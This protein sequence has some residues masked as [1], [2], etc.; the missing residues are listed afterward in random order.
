MAYKL[1]L[2]HIPEDELEKCKADIADAE[3]E[4]KYLASKVNELLDLLFKGHEEAL[5]AIQDPKSFR[6]FV[7]SLTAEDLRQEDITEKSIADFFKAD[8]DTRIATVETLDIFTVYRLYERKLKD[9]TLKR[10]ENHYRKTEQ[11]LRAELLRQFTRATGLQGIS[12]VKPSEIAKNAEALELRRS[13]DK[14]NIN[15]TVT[16]EDLI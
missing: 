12:W 14:D 4:L 7:E 8:I 2:N 9:G 13:T 16:L 3:G 11:S 10:P 6:A 1:D 15:I 5:E